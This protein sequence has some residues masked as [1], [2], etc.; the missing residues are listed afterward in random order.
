M[1]K[2]RDY[3]KELHIGDAIYKVKF[4]RKLEKGT[5]GLCDPSEYEIKILCGQSPEE[6][7][8][9]FIH[10][11]LHALLEFE[12]DMEIKHKMIY[13]LEKPLYQLLRDNWFRKS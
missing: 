11:V 5:V 9:T 13:D 6:T 3:P 7:F 10:E 2:R 12:N 8:K 4:V 1:I